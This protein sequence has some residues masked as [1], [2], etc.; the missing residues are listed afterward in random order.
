MVTN[1]IFFVDFNEIYIKFRI[2]TNNSSCHT[3]HD[4]A[5]AHIKYNIF[6]IRTVLYSY[7]PPLYHRSPL[8]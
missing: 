2:P 1:W 6:K 8:G 4:Y 3:I 7:V 5:V